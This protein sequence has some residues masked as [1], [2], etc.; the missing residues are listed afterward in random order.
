MIVSA[1]RAV[2]V[3]CSR[4]KRDDAQPLPAIER[5]DGPY[6]QVLRRY[7]RHG[8]GRVPHVWIISAEHGLIKSSEV[9][10]AYERRMTSAR[11]AELSA[12]IE[13]RFVALWTSEVTQLLISLSRDYEEAFA[14]CLSHVPPHVVLQRTA[15]GIGMRSGQLRRWL[16]T[17]SVV[18]REC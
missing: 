14:R 7:I 8:G 16:H 9:I 17:G 4:R 2:I 15:G 12:S 11:A 5:Y 13:N 3:S 6:Y 1:D 10:F 18:V